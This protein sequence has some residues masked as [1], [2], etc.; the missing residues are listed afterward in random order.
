MHFDKD[1]SYRVERDVAAPADVDEPSDFLR[2]AIAAPRGGFEVA[3]SCGDYYVRP[4]LIDEHSQGEFAMSLV[5]R[6][7]ATADNITGASSEAGMATFRIVKRG[8]EREL[9]T[10]LDRKGGVIE[11]QLRRFEYGGGE[12]EYKRMGALKKAVAKLRVTAVVDVGNSLALVTSKGRF[13]LDPDGSAFA[14]EDHGEGC[15]C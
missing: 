15:G 3:P 7:L 5:S 14:Y 13:V 1:D 2:S 10:W 11:A 6:A 8:V 9:V 4:Y 12:A